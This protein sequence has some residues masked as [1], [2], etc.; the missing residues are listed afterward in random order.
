MEIVIRVDV[1][2]AFLKQLGKKVSV[3]LDYLFAFGISA[4]GIG[5]F[6]YFCYCIYTWLAFA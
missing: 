1:L 6:A 2:R 4:A 3:F 5:S